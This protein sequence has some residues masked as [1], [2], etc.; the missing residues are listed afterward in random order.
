MRDTEVTKVKED[1]AMKRIEIT[2]N[3]F[4][5]KDQLKALGARWDAEKKVWWIDQ[6]AYSGKQWQEISSK[7]YRLGCRL[8]S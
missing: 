8:S 2:G 6:L 1:T 7:V 3:T 4:Q 5:V